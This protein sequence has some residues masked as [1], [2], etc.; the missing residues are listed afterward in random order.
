MKTSE[1]AGRQLDAWVAKALGEE[2]GTAYTEEWPNFDRVQEREAIH[3]A[4]MPG[5]NYQWCAIVVGRPGGRLPEG[6]G[7][8]VEGQNPRLAVGR[9]IVSA[10]FGGKSMDDEDSKIRRN[11]I[12][13]SSVILVL[14]W[15][16]VP[17]D[18]VGERLLGVA[19]KEGFNLS[20]KRV[21][22]AALVLLVY[23]T[24][25][26]RF[27]NEQQEGMKTLRAEYVGAERRTL[28]RWLAL[29]LACFTRFG[30]KMPVLG[31]PRERISVARRK[32]NS[33][34]AV[35]PFVEISL[36]D[37]ILG[38]RDPAGQFIPSTR[39]VTAHIKYFA[40][41]EGGDA[42]MPLVPFEFE[43]SWLQRLSLSS[44]SILWL[45]IYS[46]ASTFFMTPWVLS[47]AAIGL[48]SRRMWQVW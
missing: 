27:S 9:A 20:A 41:I 14:A 48:T 23:L 39:K 3:V 40:R 45:T 35:V 29:E 32:Q 26:F 7:G 46:K 8:W 22:A 42:P 17:L 18:L 43:L 21:R 16:K 38:T 34:E 24:L 12:A 47:F 5:K 36:N 6:R 44:V 31:D 25:R 19:S 30:W 33:V 13:V 1:L 37:A 10:R 28:K 2:P 4:P 11:L 15:L